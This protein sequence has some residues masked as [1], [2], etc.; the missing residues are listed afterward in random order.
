MSLSDMDFDSLYA[1]LNFI[2][3]LIFVCSVELSSSSLSYFDFLCRSAICRYLTLILICQS[4]IIAYKTWF[5]LLS[6]TV[7][8]DLILICSMQTYHSVI[9][10]VQFCSFRYLKL[11]LSLES[12]SLSYIILICSMEMQTA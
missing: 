1:V 6:Y 11:A 12:C 3:Y 5:V 4:V 8:S 9:H 7:C 2:F 10:S